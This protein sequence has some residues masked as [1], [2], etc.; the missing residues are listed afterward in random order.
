[1]AS[2]TLLASAANTGWRGATCAGSRAKAVGRPILYGTTRDFLHYFGIADLAEL[3][4]LDETESVLLTVPRQ[5]AAQMAPIL[6][7]LR[8]IP[9]R[10]QN[11]RTWMIQRHKLPPKPPPRSPNIFPQ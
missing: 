1:M 3:P 9:P 5:P 10:Y 4:P 2:L 7:L 11:L 6:F 8:Q